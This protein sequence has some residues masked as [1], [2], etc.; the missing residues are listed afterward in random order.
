MRPANLAANASDSSEFFMR[1]CHPFCVPRA[2]APRQ[3]NHSCN[4]C[5]KTGSRYRVPLT[6]WNSPLR[7][8]FF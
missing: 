2:M 6:S 4:R 5:R 1:W 7:L 3:L 8:A